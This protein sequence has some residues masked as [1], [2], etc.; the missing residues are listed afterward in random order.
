MDLGRQPAFCFLRGPQLP[1]ASRGFLKQPAQLRDSLRLPVGDGLG[2]APG[3]GVN[4]SRRRLGDTQVG[5]Y[6][7]VL[8]FGPF[9]WRRSACARAFEASAFETGTVECRDGCLVLLGA[10]RVGGRG[11]GLAQ[12][13]GELVTSGVRPVRG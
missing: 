4:V 5:S 2:I 11:R 10:A 7:A 3:P 1:F 9:G 12:R 8:A 13:Q 6:R